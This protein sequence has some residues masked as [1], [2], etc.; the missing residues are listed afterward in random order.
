MGAIAVFMLAAAAVLILLPQALLRPFTAEPA[1]LATGGRLL[2]VAAVFQLFDGLQAVATGALRGAGDTRSP[3]L[4]NLV[5][6]WGVGLPVAYLACF[7]LGW[8]VL[9]LWF[10]LAA[11]LTLCGV[12]LLRVWAVRVKLARSS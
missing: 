5:G 2:V 7:P 4:W 11:G 9:G 10:G 3:M 6:H 8:G 1:V 12:A